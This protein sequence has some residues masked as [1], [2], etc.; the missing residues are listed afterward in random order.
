MKSLLRGRLRRASSG[1]RSHHHWHHVEAVEPRVLLSVDVSYDGATTTRFSWD[2][3]AGARPILEAPPA[4]PSLFDQQFVAPIGS[5]MFLRIA[6]IE[7][8]ATDKQHLGQIELLGFSWSLDHVTNP[9]GSSGGADAEAPDF[10]E[11]RVASRLSKAS[12]K[13]MDA[14]VLGSTFAD[15]D[16]TIASSTSGVD[17]Y[18]VDLD[19]VNISSYQ[20]TTAADGNPLE[21]FTLRFSA[22]S[23]DYSQLLPDGRY[24]STVHFAWNAKP[25]GGT[26]ADTA[27]PLSKSLLDQAPA[28]LASNLDLFL[29]LDGIPGES[30]DAKHPNEINL[31]G[32]S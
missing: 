29:R 6:G 2:A 12:P 5:R 11:L 25:N 13:L 19:N 20:V 18:R 1:N 4:Q 23:L 8:E 27:P 17:F 24:D 31:S 14:V 9:A 22:A 21:E 26:V 3:A 10:A 32:F 30:T 7:G 16:F 28:A 15:A